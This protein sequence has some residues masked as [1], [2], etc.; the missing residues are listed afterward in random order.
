M[1]EPALL[2]RLNLA[3]QKPQTQQFSVES[4]STARANPLCGRAEAASESAMIVSIA[5]QFRNC[6]R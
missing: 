4:A 3:Q 2:R 6:D 5:R 1:G